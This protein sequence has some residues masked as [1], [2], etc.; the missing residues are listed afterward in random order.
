LFS[1]LLEAARKTSSTKSTYDECA[2][3]CSQTATAVTQL[4]EIT[5]K[6]RYYPNDCGKVSRV[7]PRLIVGDVHDA[8]S[9][10]VFLRAAV[11]V[12]AILVLLLTNSNSASALDPN[13]RV[14]QYALRNW[15]TEQGLPQ[16]WISALLQTHDGFLWVGTRGGLARF[17]GV[18]FNV[19]HSSEA[20]SIPNDII[21]SLAE[22]ISGNLWIGTPGGLTR[23]REGHF[24]TFTQ[25]D[26]LPETSIA[27]LCPDSGGGLW[28]V[29]S[30]SRIV[31]FNGYRF[32]Q[33]NSPIAGK[34]AEVNT[35][36]EDHGG[37]LW[38]ATFHGLFAF[39]KGVLDRRYSRADGLSDEAV[40]ALC[41][42]RSGTLWVAG[43]GGVDYLHEQRF[44]HRAV[45]GLVMASFVSVDRQGNLWTGSTG[46]GLFRVNEHGASRLTAA[47]GLTSDEIYTILED[48]DGGIWIGAVSGLNQ[49]QDSIFTSFGIPE[50][51]PASTRDLDAVEESDHAIWLGGGKT[52]IRLKGDAIQILDTGHRT[53]SFPYTVRSSSLSRQGLLVTS[54]AGRVSL[55]RPSSL[56]GLR[57]LTLNGAGIIF[58]DREGVLW[59]GTNENGLIRYQSNGDTQS[60]TIRNGLTDNNVRVINEDVHGDLW[61]GTVSGLVRL[62]NGAPAK[63]ASCEVVTSIWADADGSVWAGSQSGLLHYHDGSV[64]FFTQRDGLPTDTIE[65]VAE[66]DSSHLWLGTLQGVVRV[67]KQELLSIEQNKGARLSPIVFGKS[68]GLRDSEVR[69]NSVFRSQDGRIWFLT[70]KEIAVVDPRRIAP[71]P[72]LTAYVENPSLDDKLLAPSVPFVVPPGRHRIEIHYTA[73]NLSSPGRMNF[74][75]RLEGWDRDWVDAGMRRDVSYTGIPVGHYRF[76]VAVSNGWSMWNPSEATLPIVV[77]PYFYQTAWFL[78]ICV[79]ALVA[80]VIVIHNVRVSQVAAHLND[81]LHERLEERS[82]I[83]RELHDTLL[84]GVIGM[85]M[86]LYAV[87]TQVPASSPMKESLTRVVGRAHKLVDEG[88]T[89]LE[90]LRSRARHDDALEEALLSGIEDFDIPESIQVQI[91]ATGIVRTLNYVVQEDV[92]RIAREA[93]INALRHAEASTIAIEVG[94]SESALKLRVWDNGRGM[95]ADAREAGRS[96]HWGIQGMRERAEHIGGQLKLWSRPGAGTEIELRIPARLAYKSTV[97]LPKLRAVIQWMNQ[98]LGRVLRHGGI[99]RKS[100]D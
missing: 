43:N 7:L 46:S 29:T 34:F 91:T 67:D 88:R 30:Y 83:A 62:H 28:I 2:R 54:D 14:T 65:G 59:A 69:Q 45:P 87:E 19:F 35:I 85:L 84:Q 8:P 1:A 95:D 100:E 12:L 55:M 63:V 98:Q 40:Y 17:D 38:M 23:Y 89:T 90:D 80:T 36:L 61:V 53:S 56:S 51:L 49:L 64:R 31:R 13:K 18:H 47:Q 5:S 94:Y 41:L 24:V 50:G 16:G 57:K 66:D 15:T 60:Y 48:R 27:R 79:V 44:I 42:D 10:L 33:F 3:V 86:Q 25:R 82:R 37:I 70:L 93:L 73:P 20:D 39:N 4:L 99:T 74:R 52:V 76:Q 22:D 71:S 58:Y 97:E 72:L 68:D 92:Y 11:S 32:E 21:T 81:R 75:Y 26:G 9:D 6:S 96:G 78:T 77:Q